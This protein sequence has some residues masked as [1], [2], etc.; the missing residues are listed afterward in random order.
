MINIILT[1]SWTISC[2]VNNGLSMQSR[3]SNRSTIKANQLHLSESLSLNYCDEPICY[4]ND[5]GQDLGCFDPWPLTVYGSIDLYSVCPQDPSFIGTTFNIYHSSKPE[6]M[7]H[8]L[9][10]INSSDKIV[11]FIPG[12]KNVYNDSR[13]IAMKD[14]LLSVVNVVILVDFANG[15]D[16]GIVYR[17]TDFYNFHQAAANTQI[18]GRQIAVSLKNLKLKRGIDYDNVHLICFSLGT[19][20]AHFMGS[21]ALTRFGFQVGRITSEF[22]LFFNA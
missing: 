16:P 13:F 9:D 7:T 2:L 15:A 6:Q 20:V 3:V 10:S 5:D 8:S 21:Y 1:F 14:E 11:F 17:V 12:Y 22:R 18:V 19:Q 4:K